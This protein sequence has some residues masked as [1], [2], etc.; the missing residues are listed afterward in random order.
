M[1]I[2]DSGCWFIYD[3]ARS[4]FNVRGKYLV[5]DGSGTNSNADFC[6]FLSN[7][8]KIRTTA[9]ALNGN[10]TEFIYMAFASSPLVGSNDIPGNAK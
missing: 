8:I 9:S 7:G 10:G 4:P 6:D 3:N 2:R 5:A 1:C